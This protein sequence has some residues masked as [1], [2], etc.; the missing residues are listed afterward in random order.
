MN[1]SQ[2]VSAVAEKAGVAN[3]QAD[4]VL[5]AF[6]DV[7][8]DAVAAGDKVALTG[9]LSLERVERAARTGRNPR[10]G[11]SID[12]PAGFGVKASPGS[13]LKQAVQS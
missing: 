12:I 13:G 5:S 10:T 6:Q 4:A 3:N 9:F 11:E 8:T 1:R 7:V 2:L